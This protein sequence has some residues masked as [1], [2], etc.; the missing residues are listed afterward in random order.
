MVFRKS[1]PWVATWGGKSVH[2]AQSSVQYVSSCEV[3]KELQYDYLTETLEN[4]VKL[5][6]PMQGWCV[7]SGFLHPTFEAL[8]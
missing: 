2:E 5:M 1:A 3:R 8:I 7:G 4:G 6:G